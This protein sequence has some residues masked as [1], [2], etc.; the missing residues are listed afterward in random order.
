MNGEKPINCP[1]HLGDGAYATFSM[2]DVVI[3]ANHHDPAIA[4]DKV[5]LD[6][7]ALK[8]LVT[9]ARACG[10]RF[11]LDPELHPCQTKSD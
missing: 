7:T 8:V 10:A 6:A 4:S 5:Y 2:T 9:T 3:T 11:G 1:V